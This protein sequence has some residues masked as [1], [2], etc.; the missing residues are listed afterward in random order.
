MVTPPPRFQLLDVVQVPIAVSQ[1]GRAVIVGRE[2]S[3]ASKFAA[4]DQWFYF[5]AFTPT[6]MAFK[7]SEPELIA[8]QGKEAK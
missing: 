6:G 2:F 8:W 4:A 3:A 1:Q 7:A 5:L